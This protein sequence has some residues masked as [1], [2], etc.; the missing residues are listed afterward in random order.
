[1]TT[2]DPAPLVVE[3]P[4]QPKPEGK[5]SWGGWI[6]FISL[7]AFLSFFALSSRRYLDPRVANPDVEGRPRPV[8]FLFG[9]DHW[10]YFHEVGTVLALITLIVVFIVGWRRNPGSPVMLM[11]LCTTLIVWQDP[12]MNYFTGRSPGRWCRCRR[13]W[14]RS[15]CSAT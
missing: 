5:R 4:T 6:A 11:F 9:F 8:E 3:T 14:N 1:M 15:S 7:V 2:K 13:R 12:I 10:V